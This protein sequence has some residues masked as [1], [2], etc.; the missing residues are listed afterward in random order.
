MSLFWTLWITIITLATIFGCGVLLWWCTKDKMGVDEGSDM[1]HSYDG[2]KEINNPLPKW[3]RY[4]FWMTI[5]FALGYLVLYPGLGAWGNLLGWHSANQSVLSLQ[6]S[7]AAVE[8][9]KAAGQYVQYDQEKAQADKTFG[10]TFKKLAYQAD[11]T[12][13]RPLTE[14]A[15]DPNAMKVGKALFLQNCALCHGSDARGQKGFPNLTDNDWLYGGEPEVIKTTILHGRIG[16]MPAWKDTLGPDGVREVVS[17]AL[18]L[19]GRKVDPREAEAGKKRFVLCAACHGPDGKGN[20]AV[21]APN[22]TDQIWLYG[23]TRANVEET[24]KYGRNGQMP[25]WQSIL[26]DD[27]VHLLAAYVFSLSQNNSGQTGMAT[28]EQAKAAH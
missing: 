24:V 6:E 16:A 13:F 18:S 7:N 8:K 4:M 15:N 2:I 17:Y 14:V 20:P 28:N 3:W 25:A 1:G 19:S 11:G 23:G 27:K 26:G 12:T 9:A 10:E 21:G 22:L 5:V